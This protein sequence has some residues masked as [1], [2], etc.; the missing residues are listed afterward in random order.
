MRHSI[1]SRQIEIEDA[2]YM[3]CAVSVESGSNFFCS[4]PRTLSHVRHTS[5]SCRYATFTSSSASRIPSSQSS[6]LTAM[7]I[8]AAHCH[9]CSLPP[10][11]YV[12][13][14]PFLPSHTSSLPRHRLRPRRASP[15]LYFPLLEHL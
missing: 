9:R 4:L 14:A 11:P 5:A 2:K 6:A 10:E 7:G 8:E 1:I 3:S 15:R 13:A 12:V